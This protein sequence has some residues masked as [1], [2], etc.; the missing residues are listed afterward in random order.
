MNAENAERIARDAHA[1]IVDRSGTPYIKHVERVA[2][3]APQWARPLAWLH[4]TVEDTDVTFEQLAD[5]GLTDV[6]LAAL[7][8][9]T[10]DLD[11]GVTYMDWIR[12]IAA[13][14][15]EAGRMA[16]A[17]KLIDVEDNISR[18]AASEADRQMKNGRYAR[19]RKI[20]VRAMQQ[21]GE[22]EPLDET[23]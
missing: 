5:A 20:L 11:S 2:Q 6:Q 23:R 15:G 8:L 4:D 12:Q 17:V 13:A 14:P 7:Q 9:V 1:G 21:A 10:R 19:A 16:R 18:P 3:A 22:L